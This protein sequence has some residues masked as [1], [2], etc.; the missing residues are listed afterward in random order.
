MAEMQRLKYPELAPEGVA[1]LSAVE[2]YVNTGTGLD[3]VLLELVRLRCSLLNGCEY[4]VALHTKELRRHNEPDSRIVAVARWRGSSA[5]TKREQAALRWAE[6]ETNIQDG[7]AQDAEYRAVQEHFS[8]VELVNLTLAIASIN[9]WNRMA[10]TFRPQ[11]RGVAPPAFGLESGSPESGL[12][13][14]EGETR[15]DEQ[16]R[17]ASPEHAVERSTDEHETSAVGDDGGKVA[18]D[19]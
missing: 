1:A 17:G 5:Y 9:A 2:H 16:A 12:K 11:W 8:D 15:V 3:P 10:I 14:S 6:V 7:N 13:T 18:V 19:D 4:C